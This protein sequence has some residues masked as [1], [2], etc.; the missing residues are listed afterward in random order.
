M[1]DKLRWSFLIAS[2]FLLIFSRRLITCPLNTTEQ[3][4]GW[5]GP[6]PVQS[7]MVTSRHSGVGKLIE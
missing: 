4:S 2:L 3:K 7:G 5:A 6:V 1:E